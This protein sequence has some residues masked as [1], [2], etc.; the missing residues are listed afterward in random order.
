MLSILGQ[1]SHPQHWQEGPVFLEEVGREVRRV[2]MHRSLCEDLARR[3]LELSSLLS[4]SQSKTPEVCGI[5]ALSKNS[6]IQM[7]SCTKTF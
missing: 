6:F 5:S 3:G 1:G 4:S 7:K 2:S